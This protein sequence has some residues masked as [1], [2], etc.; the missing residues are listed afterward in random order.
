MLSLENKIRL[1]E[2]EYSFGEV[3]K[4]HIIGDTYQIIEAIDNDGN[5]KF[6]SYVNFERTGFSYNSLEKAITG[7]IAYK[8]EGANSQANKYFWKMID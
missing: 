3:V 6:S 1:I 5:Q 2:S 4:T 8:Y 7:A